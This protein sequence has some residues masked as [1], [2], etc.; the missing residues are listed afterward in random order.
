MRAILTFFLIQSSKRR[1][2]EI[3][4]KKQSIWPS[5]SNSSP[6]HH[7]LRLLSRVN[8]K[9][10]KYRTESKNISTLQNSHIAKRHT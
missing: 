10:M 7:F 1:L 4:L 3:L 9:F 2:W 6:Y 8:H 5:I